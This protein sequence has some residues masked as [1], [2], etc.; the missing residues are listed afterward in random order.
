MACRA[1]RLKPTAA[2]HVQSRMRTTFRV[3]LD[4]RALRAGDRVVVS[5]SVAQLTLWGD[6]V[7]MHRLEQLHESELLVGGPWA[8]TAVEEPGRGHQAACIPA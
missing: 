1:A 6:G 8:W 7:E 5:G 3:L 4:P 2:D